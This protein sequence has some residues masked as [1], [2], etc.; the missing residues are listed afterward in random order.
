[1]N[2]GFIY[3]FF[4]SLVRLMYYCNL[5]ELFKF[6]AKLYTGI[7]HKRN[8]DEAT[9]PDVIRSCNIAI[10]IY[11]VFKFS[12]LLLL[13]VCEVNSFFSK[14]VIYYLLFSN[15]FTYFYYHV[16]GSKFGQRIDRDTL[17]RKFLNSLLAISYYL[18]C[19]AYLYEVHYSQMIFWP[20]SL[21]DSTNAIFLSVANAFTLTY[22]G[23]KPLTQDIRVVFMSELINTF[24]FFTVIIT[25]SIPNH[26]GKENNEL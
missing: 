2:N 20:D 12:V 9:I 15:L 18:L 11:Q 24:L 8:G 4:D 22:G 5:V 23:F 7:M 17:N 26:A 19:Y 21:V 14:I 6:F 10:D 1:M 13:W 16:W 3:P 25:N